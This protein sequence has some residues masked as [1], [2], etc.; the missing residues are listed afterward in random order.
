M[1]NVTIQQIIHVLKNQIFDVHEDDTKYVTREFVLKNNLNKCFSAIT[2]NIQTPGIDYNLDHWEKHVLK[3]NENNFVR[4]IHKLYALLNRE[5]ILKYFENLDPNAF[6][7]PMMEEDDM[8]FVLNSYYTTIVYDIL[9]AG[10]IA[11]SDVIN[12]SQNKVDNSN[13]VRKF[14]E[15]VKHVKQIIIPFLESIPIYQS[16]ANS[17]KEATKTYAA[18]HYRATSSLLLI[19]IEGLV[20]ILGN[21]MIE[22]QEIDKSLLKPK[23]HSLNSFLKDIPWKTDYVIEGNRLMFLTG[24]FM[25]RED[26]EPVKVVSISLKTR[27]DFLKRR[28]KESRNSILHGDVEFGETWDLYVN[29]SALFEVYETIKYYE[30]LYNKIK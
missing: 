24:D 23:Y 22:K 26:Y 19:E 10:N 1:E 18:K 21:F 30:F 7:H 9:W 15:M 20:R 29:L 2:E 4:Y 14:P 12:L 3:R 11:V 6:Y 5:S 17:L 28:F 8:I 16:K 27:L 13:L 25:F